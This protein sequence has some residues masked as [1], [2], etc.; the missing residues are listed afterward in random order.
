FPLGTKVVLDQATR[1]T[2]QHTATIE[3]EVT[4]HGRWV[5]GLVRQGNEWQVWH[6]QKVVP[7]QSASPQKLGLPAA[8]SPKLNLVADLQAKA[9]GCLPEIGKRVPVVFVHG[10]AGNVG[11][12]GRDGDASSLFFKVNAM[13]AVAPERFD[14][15]STNLLW[16]DH[17][18]IGPRLAQRISCLAESSRKAGGPGKVIVVVH[19]MGGLATRFAAS[20]TVN[21][22][23]VAD[24]LGL[25]VTI[26]TPNLGSAQANWTLDV[27]RDICAGFVPFPVGVVVGEVCSWALDFLTAVGGLKVNSEKLKVLPPLPGNVP[28]QAIAGDVQTPWRYFDAAINRPPSDLVV[29]VDSAHWGATNKGWGDG[30]TKFTCMSAFALPLFTTADC[31][32]GRLLNNPKVHEKVLESIAKYLG[33]F[34]T[35][36]KPQGK[37]VTVG[38]LTIWIPEKWEFFGSPAN[39]NMSILPVGTPHC[40]DGCPPLGFVEYYNWRADL[41]SCSGGRPTPKGTLSAGGKIVNYFEYCTGTPDASVLWEIP[42]EIV[43]RWW[44]P[45]PEFKTVLSTAQWK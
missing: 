28:L 2:G 25:V 11:A 33:S 34:Q 21:G 13:G 38:R 3:A 44:W 15:E 19:S 5:L 8:G 18:N 32:H 24:D 41:P 22:R 37:P 23:K 16:I 31:E 4:G 40:V 14:Y 1:K 6:T 12:W 9:E 36:P 20:Q 42:G 27:V 43:F 39:D 35:K 7:G 17:P 26:G 29:G 30:A 45:L 10:I